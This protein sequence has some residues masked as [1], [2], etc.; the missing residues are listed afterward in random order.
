MVFC[1]STI[2]KTISDAVVGQLRKACLSQH[3]YVACQLVDFFLWPVNAHSQIINVVFACLQQLC[4][5]F[6][7]VTR[8]LGNI[9][10]AYNESLGTVLFDWLCRKAVLQLVFVEL[11]YILT[12]L[13]I[14]KA[15]LKLSRLAK[16]KALR[17]KCRFKKHPLIG[18]VYETLSKA[19]LRT[20]RFG[21]S[22]LA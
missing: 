16:Q 8:F 9:V 21:F 10:E 7:V 13:H 18:K 15:R 19:P 22:A 5:I 17:R 11:S 14:K 12:I 4:F 6:F 2:L 1:L 3:F 20:S